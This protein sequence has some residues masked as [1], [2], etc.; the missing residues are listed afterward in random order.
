[1]NIKKLLG[2][3]VF[4]GII[5]FILSNIL[6][7][8]KPLEQNT[9]EK[10]IFAMN[11]ADR[12][13]PGEFETVEI[14]GREYRQA[15]G[16]PGEY[17]GEL[18]NSTIGEGPRTFNPW[19]AKD[20]TSS[21]MGEIMFNG[22]VSTDAYTGE[23]VPLLAKSVEIDETGT[24]H[25]V[26][27][28][29]GLKWSDGE[30]ITSEDVVFTWNTIIAEG[31]GN[32]SARDNALV[33]GKMPKVEAV[34][35]LTVKF[36]TPRP[37]APFL[38]QL[39]QNIAPKHILES[40]TK[41]GKK[42]FNSFWGVNTPPK[43]LVSS[44]MFR[45]ERYIPAQRLEF[46]RNPDYYMIDRL[47]QKLPYLD[48]YIFHIVGD[49]N[50]QVLKFESGQLDILSLSGSNVSRFKE[51]EKYSDYKIYNL[52][53]D[54]GTMFLMFNLNKRKNDDGKYYV[55]PEKQRWFNDKNFRKAVSLAV[56]R[57][58]A[59]LNILRGVG[60]PLYTAESLSS[61]YLNEKLKDGK[62][63]DI[64]KAR[65]LLKEAGFSWNEQGMLV[66]EKGNV[67]EFSLSTNAGNTERESLGV[68]VKEDLEKLG[69]K[70]NFKPIEFNVLVGKL[71]DSLDW[72]AAII[73][74]TGSPLEPHSGRNVWSSTGALHMF[75]QRKGEDLINQTNIRDWE[76]E[77]DE[78][79]EKG[80]TVIDFEERKEYYDRY[81]E[82]VWE[83]NP[84]IYIYSNLRIIAIREKFQNID[85]TPLGGVLHNI[86]EIY[87]NQDS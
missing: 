37:F 22:L 58:N 13:P 56:D 65:Q 28:R 77:L 7:V 81:Q 87:I 80:S 21:Q 12:E 69:I 33:D 36:T 63:R 62:P 83:Y 54:T 4:A 74:L 17:G 9:Q 39:S 67:V 71:S 68:M 18:H 76:Q 86:E 31:Y 52:G 19:N 42:A 79:F 23:V 66:D 70:V 2:Y 45:L 47:G 6:H 11:K 43:E 57:K 82:I 27:L 14:N 78:I 10:E 26:I 49:L 64:E 20:N 29:K 25:T 24:V 59:V 44:G 61:I 51:L 16:L 3:L 50:N 73:G 30:P 46:V 85:P 8:D 41:Q 1:M 72:E 75:N 53:P 15:R 60:A 35:E 32:T 40:V 34:D 38:R 84:L 48:K 55:D 5:I